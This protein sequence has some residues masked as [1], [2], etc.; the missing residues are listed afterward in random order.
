MPSSP[1]IIRP[2]RRED[3]IDLQTHC[4]SRNTLE[5]V[6]QQVES[7]LARMAEGQWLHLVAQVD[8]IVVGSAE[9]KRETHR[10]LRHRAEWTG[11]VVDGEYQGRGIARALLAE[12]LTQAATWGIELLTVGVRG[13]TGAEGVYHR[14]GF[15][16][17]ARLPS[18]FKEVCD[19]KLLVFDDVSLYLPVPPLASPSGPM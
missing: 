13:G 3:A 5:E 1:V 4:F 15:R 6:Q 12:T 18:G 2:V 19:G 16:E 10:L 14:L 11:V 8:E 7:N 9:L 17:Y